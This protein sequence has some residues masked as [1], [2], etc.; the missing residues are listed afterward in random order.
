MANS[1]SFR[2]LRVVVPVLVLLTIGMAV[3]ESRASEKEGRLIVKVILDDPDKTP[4][5]DI[6]IEAH[7]F[8]AS[9]TS[10]TSIVLKMVK[11]GQYEAALPPGV[12][13][14]FVSEPSSTPRCRRVLITAGSTPYWSLMLEHDE[15]YQER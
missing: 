1:F 5:K 15:L 10:E 14:V 9:W 12:Y 13:D 7:S 11:V 6:Y 3:D 2:L 4:P 8:N